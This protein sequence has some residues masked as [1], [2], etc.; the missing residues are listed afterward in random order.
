MYWHPVKFDPC[1]KKSC[2]NS[3]SSPM[4]FQTYCW[5][6]VK[7]T[8]SREFGTTD[9]STPSPATAFLGWDQN[10]G[11][12]IKTSTGSWLFWMLIHTTLVFFHGQSLDTLPGT[13]PVFHKRCF[14]GMGVPML[15]TSVAY[16]HM[17][18]S[19]IVV[20]KKD[21]KFKVPAKIL[22][23]YDKLRFNFGSW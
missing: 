15:S 1:P 8:T 2:K 3:P 9:L 22:T 12:H 20:P 10:H 23:N 5:N 14:E 11:T 16:V 6:H 19:L 4:V 17:W 13:W 21:R 18:N 7:S